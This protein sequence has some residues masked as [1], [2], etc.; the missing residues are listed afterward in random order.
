MNSF[1]IT[2][3]VHCF[4]CG[5]VSSWPAYRF[6]RRLIKWADIPI[7]LRI[8]HSLLWF[9]QSKAFFF[10]FFFYI[11]KEADFFLE[12][13]WFFYEPTYVANL[14]SGSSAPSK[15]SSYIWKFSVH[16]LLEPSLKDFEH[17]L[18]SMGNECNCTIVWRFFDIALLWDWNENWP[19][20]VL[21]HLLSFL[22]LLTKWTMLKEIFYSQ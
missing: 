11:V 10:F 22:S 9:T 2:D 19:F 20:P 14:I 6:L 3:P 18:T 21:R 15:P 1:I 8:F 17:N 12:F 5:S 13:P 4:M 16:V 7:S